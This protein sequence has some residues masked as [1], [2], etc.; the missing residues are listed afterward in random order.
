ML[1]FLTMKNFPEHRKTQ[2]SR[3]L[4]TGG[5]AVKRAEKLVLCYITCPA[6]VA[7]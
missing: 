6:A 2:P 5:L 1:G 4:P 7:L 3:K